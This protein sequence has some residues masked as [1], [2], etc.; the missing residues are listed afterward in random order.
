MFEDNVTGSFPDRPDQE[1][2][3]LFDDGE[4]VSEYRY[5]QPSSDENPILL[6]AN[7]RFWPHIRRFAGLA[8]PPGPMQ[9]APLY[10]EHYGARY[11]AIFLVV[12]EEEQADE[13]FNAYV[14]HVSCRVRDYKNNVHVMTI[15]PTDER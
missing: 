2:D 14:E 5:V 8:R 3:E 6:I 9:L 10:S 13:R 12:T 7:K 11:S 4:W 15:R 1:R